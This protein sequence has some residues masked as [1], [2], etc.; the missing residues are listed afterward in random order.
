MALRSNYVPNSG[1]NVAFRV[2]VLYIKCNWKNLFL[3][4]LHSWIM[5]LSIFS[6][7]IFKSCLLHKNVVINGIQD[8]RVFGFYERPSVIGKVLIKV[9]ADLTALC[10]TL[11]TM[12]LFSKLLKQEY[13][14]ER[15]KSS[16]RKFN[17]RYEDLIKHYE[18]PLLRILRHSEAWPFTVTSSTDL[19]L[20]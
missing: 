3:L 17:G 15:L 9:T 4:T 5:C 13:T 16:L 10:S 19:T 11:R 20:L 1:E 7:V 8:I 6:L 18:V 2:Y 14:M 12:R